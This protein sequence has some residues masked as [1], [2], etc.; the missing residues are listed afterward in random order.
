MSGLAVLRQR[1]VDRIAGVPQS[2]GRQFRTVGVYGE[3]PDLERTFTDLCIH[4]SVFHPLEA[5]PFE[6]RIAYE[7]DGLRYRDAVKAHAFPKRGD[8]D[9]GQRFRQIDM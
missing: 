2:G 5:R 3:V 9:V 7:S 1:S 6:C 4:A 8:A